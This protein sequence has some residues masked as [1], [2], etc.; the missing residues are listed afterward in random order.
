MTARCVYVPMLVGTGIRAAR[1]PPL[2]GNRG[3]VSLVGVG[4]GQDTGRGG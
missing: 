4:G 3:M 1:S 2:G